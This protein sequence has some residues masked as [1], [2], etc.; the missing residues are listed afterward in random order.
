MIEILNVKGGDIYYQSVIQIFGNCSTT[1]CN[2]L[3]EVTNGDGPT[4]AWKIISSYF[5]VT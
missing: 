3:I 4:I 2:E 5:K 1:N